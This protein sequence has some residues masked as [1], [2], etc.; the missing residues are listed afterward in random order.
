MTCLPI[1]EV[2]PCRPPTCGSVVPSTEDDTRLLRG[3]LA[4]DASSW[5]EFT[6]RY[7]RLLHGCIAKVTVRFP[8]VVGTDDVAEIYGL[9][10]LNLLANDM[11]RLRTF[12]P[13]RGMRLGSWLGLLAVHAA[14]DYLRSLRRQPR[15]V[16]L[17]DVAEPVAELPDADHTCERVR[18]SQQLAQLMNDLSPRD[19]EFMQ[20]YFGLGFSPEQVASR[21]GISIKTVYTKRHKIQARLES[22]L[23]RQAVAA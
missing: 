10:C 1:S 16:C 13:T 12:D 5:R 3:L 14:Y 8:A 7:S 6:S 20:L 23:E 9:F 18:Q 15:G 22:M 2:V 4:H 21:M 11:H 17:D 19:R